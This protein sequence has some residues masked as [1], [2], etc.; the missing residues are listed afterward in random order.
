MA[1]KRQHPCTSTVK[2]YSLAK[3]FPEFTVSFDSALSW[4]YHLIHSYLLN[5]L[6]RGRGVI[7]SHRH[8]KR[9]GKGASRRRQKPTE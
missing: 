8:G 3:S 2:L 9:V 1:L 5:Q 6:V 4:G 7:F